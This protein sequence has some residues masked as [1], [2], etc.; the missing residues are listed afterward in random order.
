VKR[1][2]APSPTGH[3]R[4]GGG[5]HVR[6]YPRAAAFWALTSCLLGLSCN[7]AAP[8]RTWRPGPSA[9]SIARSVRGP[10]APSKTGGKP[11]TSNRAV[12]KT[13]PV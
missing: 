3:G 6:A 10:D 4:L 12:V 11:G 8:R 1:R 2:S 9:T 13:R 5:L 7:L